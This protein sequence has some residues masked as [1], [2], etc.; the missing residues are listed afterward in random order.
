MEATRIRPLLGKD[1]SSVL[2]IWNRALARD[3]ISEQRFV[4]TILADPDYWPGEDSGFTSPWLPW[5]V[6]WAWRSSSQRSLP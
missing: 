1:I 5:E 2:A 3:P 4:R 6:N